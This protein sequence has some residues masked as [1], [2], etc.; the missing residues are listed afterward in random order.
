MPKEKPVSNSGKRF[1][2]YNG[3]LFANPIPRS[4]VAAANFH[5]C[6]CTTKFSSAGDVLP[7]PLSPFSRF[8]K[9]E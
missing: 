6:G 3:S 5:Q 2:S 7:I 9:T 8:F 4:I 1:F